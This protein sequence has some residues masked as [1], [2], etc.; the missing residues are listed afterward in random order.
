[1]SKTFTNNGQG[2]MYYAPADTAVPETFSAIVAAVTATDSAFKPGANVHKDGLEITPRNVNTELENW[3]AEV[4]EQDVNSIWKFKDLDFLSVESLK[5]VFGSDNVTASG[6]DVLVNFD[7]PMPEPVVLVA[8]MKD[9][10]KGVAA[11]LRN[12]KCTAIEP[13]KF[14]KGDY[15]VHDATMTG[16]K[17]TSGKSSFMVTSGNANAQAGK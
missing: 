2:R 13:Y 1:M 4:T 11:V 5:A 14:T 7:G 3:N 6:D 15:S 10:D 8:V 17:P 16:I 9:G 12:G